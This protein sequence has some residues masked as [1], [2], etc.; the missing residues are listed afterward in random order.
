MTPGSQFVGIQPWFPFGLNRWNWLT[1][2]IPAERVAALRIAA[3]LALLADLLF[4]YLS[5][6]WV[7]FSPGALGGRDLFADRFRPGHLDWSMLRVLPD[8]WG[9]AAVFGVWFAGAV[10]LLVG[11]RPLVSGLVVLACA[12]SV[13]NINPFLNN[14]GDRLRNTLFLTVAVSCSGAVWGVSSVRAKG[15]PRPVLVAGWP[16]KVLLVQLAVMYFFNGYYKII[17]P[18]WRAG[19]VIYYAANDLGWSLS[20]GAATGVPVWALQ[21]AAWVTLVWE[22]G[23]PVLV[24]LKGTRTATLVL[25]F[26]FHL[27]TFLTL[28]VGHFALY[29][30]ACYAAFVPWEKWTRSP[31]GRG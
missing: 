13:T 24:M 19:Y 14:G 6:F 31:S 18:A 21:A 26:A 12:I 4:G 15:D 23:F 17:S 11:W 5:H 27:A 7:F 16:V 10:A 20:P 2:P 22:L 28:E 3:A 25:G 8:A 30:M 29:A 9:P 1:E